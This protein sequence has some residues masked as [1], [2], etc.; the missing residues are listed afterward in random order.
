MR[1]VRRIVRLMVFPLALVALAARINLVAL[2]RTR[3]EEAMHRARGQAGACRILT[4][5]L[6][7]RVVTRGAPA[8]SG[9]FL[10]VSNHLGALD[11]F[12]L[13]TSMPLAFVAKLEMASWPVMGWVCRS[14]GVIFV[15]R[16]RRSAAGRMVAEVQERMRA[17]VPVLVFPEGT[18]GDG[19]SI[20]PFRSGAFEAAVG[21]EDIEVLPIFLTAG[22]VGD[23]SGRA[24]HEAIVWHRTETMAAHIWRLLGYRRIELELRLGKP[25][26]ASGRDR[27]ALLEAS[28]ES[29]ERLGAGLLDPG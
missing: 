28:Q 22:R 17:G 9:T 15:D 26:A 5:I 18:V 23:L 16:G 27:R 7:V 20:L 29:V 3:E 11:G 4:R 10:V 19:A 6:G 13:A 25:I 12:A 1:S 24:A 2:F 21:S 8:D 14:V